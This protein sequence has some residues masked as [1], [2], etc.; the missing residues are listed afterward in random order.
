MLK[1]EWGDYNMT[2]KEAYRVLLNLKST[3]NDKNN[4]QHSTQFIWMSFLFWIG[5]YSKAL[6]YTNKLSKKR[7]T[8]EIEIYCWKGVMYYF[9]KDYSN[10]ILFL[11]KAEIIDPKSIEIKYLL[12]EIFFATA[13]LE[14]AEVRYRSLIGSDSKYKILGLYGIGS[15]LLKT[16]RCDE[17]LGF[18]NKALLYIK[19]E[20]QDNSVK[21]LNKKGLC[22]IRLN[23][24]E[25]ARL[26]FEECVRISPDDYN[27]QLN[28]ALTL[29]KLKK[30]EEAAE[31]YKKILS[32]TPN[33]IIAINNCASC[34][35]ECDKNYEALEYYN[36]GLNI[37]P[38]NPDLLINKGYC[39]YKLG[40]YNIALE[41]LNEAEKIVKNDIILYNNKALCLVAL[42]KYDEALKL[43]NKLLDSNK[44]HSDDLLFNK[45]YCLVK[46]GMYSEA[47]TC[48]ANIK[49]KGSHNFDFYILKGICFEQLG[50][51]DAAL[52]NFN[53]SLI[54]A[55]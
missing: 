13:Q 44:C 39:L 33:N 16:D 51:Y 8:A 10:A 46:K 55:R 30:F 35:A 45:A 41:C 24:V 5:K 11:E 17:A 29:S 6:Y 22:L 40:N 34:L 1:K 4:K 9:L 37:D 20:D 7:S 49:N 27:V 23:K 36:I 42:G 43:F 54:I 38:N 21:I 31:I 32:K 50:N 48:L 18:F 26:C 47:L 3:E 12:A 14:K 28:L 52:K 25:E 2:K 19:P 15:C 53:K